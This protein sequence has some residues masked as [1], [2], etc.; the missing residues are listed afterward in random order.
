MC[1]VWDRAGFAGLGFQISA[2]NSLPALRSLGISPP[3]LQ[4]AGKAQH[5]RSSQD[6]RKK[7]RGEPGR[8]QAEPRRV[9]G[10]C[11]AAA[12]GGR[13][14][15]EELRSPGPGASP[16]TALG[17]DAFPES[18][19]ERNKVW[20]PPPA[21]S[22]TPSPPPLC[23]LLLRVPPQAPPTAA[24]LRFAGEQTHFLPSPAFRGFIY[25]LFAQFV[26]VSLPFC[27]GGVFPEAFFWG[28]AGECCFVCGCRMRRTSTCG[29][30]GGGLG[31]A[32][33]RGRGSRA[34][35]AGLR[36]RALSFCFTVNRDGGSAGA[37]SL[38]PGCSGALMM[39]L[40]LG[41]LSAMVFW[42][43]RSGLGRVWGFSCRLFSWRAAC[44]SQG[45]S[46]CAAAA[47]DRAVG[48]GLRGLGFSAGICA[49]G[50]GGEDFIR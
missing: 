40:C 42:G 32:A 37:A 39:R 43:G 48:L 50:G 38:L 24:V 2:A 45:S 23:S 34:P 33:L 1:Q 16:L 14:E 4:T 3:S 21:L 8:C 25:F 46:A 28:C 13:R 19:R 12:G 44:R 5:R 41:E 30:A 22:F 47:P 9:G 29:G 20:G 10:S 35:A 11:A 49:G 36:C 18:R 27:R 15:E 17:S 26:S 6:L 31:R 7:G